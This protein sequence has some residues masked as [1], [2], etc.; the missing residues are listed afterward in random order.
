MRSKLSPFLDLVENMCMLSAIAMTL[1]WL[2]YYMLNIIWCIIT[3]DENGLLDLTQM[4]SHATCSD[5]GIGDGD[6]GGSRGDPGATAA[7]SHLVRTADEPQVTIAGWQNDCSPQCNEGKRV[8]TVDKN[9][10]AV[11]IY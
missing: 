2:D 7:T 4:L 8:D 9:T 11:F 3:V 5:S 1:I 10:H 6:S